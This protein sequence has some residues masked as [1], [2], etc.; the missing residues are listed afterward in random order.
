MVWQNVKLSFIVAS[1]LLHITLWSSS[2][3]LSLCLSDDAGWITTL[4]SERLLLMETLAPS[5]WADR[6]LINLIG[7]IHSMHGLLH[8]ISPPIIFFYTNRPPTSTSLMKHLKCQ[9]KS[10][11]QKF[12]VGTFWGNPLLFG[13]C[14]TQKLRRIII[15]LKEKHSSQNVDAHIFLENTKSVFD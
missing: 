12:E 10:L 6:P 8:Y 2:V 7:K 1:E 13:L 3:W 11:E 15:I 9:N 14:N 4:M 5:G